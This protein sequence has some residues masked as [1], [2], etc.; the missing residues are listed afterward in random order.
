M[1]AEGN[2]GAGLLDQHLEIPFDLGSGSLAF[3]ENVFRPAAIGDAL[4][5]RLCV[6]NSLQIF[7]DQAQIVVG[8]TCVQRPGHHLQQGA[9]QRMP[10]L[11]G[12]ACAH[13][14][15]KLVE[16]QTRRQPCG[17]R[18]YVSACEWPERSASRKVP[19]GVHAGLT[20]EW[21]SAA[22]E[23][24]VCVTIS[25]SDLRI[26]DVASGANALLALPIQV[27]GNRRNGD[28]AFPYHVRQAG[29][30]LRLLP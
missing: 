20:A 6:W 26:N 12:L 11:E 15:H 4:L 7:I 8:H 10:V 3:C 13:N 30:I 14:L 29:V 24:W 19:I 18:R 27:E 25:A 5:R 17:I 28:A 23:E 21:I 16:G 9:L 2:R 22:Q 1:I